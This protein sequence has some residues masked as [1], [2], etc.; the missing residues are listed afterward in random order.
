MKYLPDRVRK[1]TRDEMYDQDKE[2]FMRG[3]A[4]TNRHEL[5]IMARQVESFMLHHE[6]IDIHNHCFLYL[7]D[8]VVIST[9]IEEHNDHLEE[10]LQNP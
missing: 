4:K 7:D 1:S 2:R 9:T 5:M 6:P 3:E 10:V 8:S